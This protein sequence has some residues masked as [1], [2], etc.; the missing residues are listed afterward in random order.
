MPKFDKA[1][2]DRFYRDPHTRSSTPQ[3]AK[4]QAAF[5]AAYLR[6]L[7]VRI[8]SII[9]IGCGVG[10][11]LRALGRIYP[12]ARCEGV[13]YSDYLCREYGWTQGSVAA[14]LPATKADLVVC[15]DV[16]PYLEDDEAAITT[17]PDGSIAAAWVVYRDKGDRV[18]VRTL[19]GGSW[20]KTE[21]VTRQP[22]DLFRCSLAVD[23][24]G[25]LWAFW[26]ERQGTGWSIWG[27]Q[28]Q[29]G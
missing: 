11:T 1:Y 10:H 16:V 18:M 8:R 28:R 24:G 6:Y 23:G 4:K 29:N 13:E 2:Y 7:G 12:N 9:D 17:L 25:N 20:S 15:N 21:E 19:S 14:Y 5:I 22:G 3:A 26:S 27:R